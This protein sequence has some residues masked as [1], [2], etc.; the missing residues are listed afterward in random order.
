MKLNP[1]PVTDT[2]RQQAAADYMKAYAHF[3]W[4]DRPN[5]AAHYRACAA[6]YGERTTEVDVVFDTTEGNQ[7]GK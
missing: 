5:T 2:D 3:L 1:A 6:M 7:V 4:A